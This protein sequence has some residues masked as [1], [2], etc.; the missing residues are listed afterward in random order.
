MTDLLGNLPSKLIAVHLNYRSRARQRAKEPAFPSYFLKAPSTL[1]SSESTIHRPADCELLAYE[2]EIAL[3]IGTE[4]H[5]IAPEVAWKHVSG[6]TAA[7]DFGLYDLRYADPGSNVHSKGLDGSTPIGPVVLNAQRLDPSSVRLRTWVN[8]TVVQDAQ[9]DDDMLFDFGYV[10]ADL[11][12]FMTL[13]PGDVILTGTPAGSSVVQPGDIVEVEVS[14][15]DLD[16]DPTATGR[17]RTFVAHDDFR[18]GHLHPVPRADKAAVIAAYGHEPADQ[19]A[20]RG[21]AKDPEVARARVI[22]LLTKVST[23]TI[24][25]QLRRR[26]IM[27]CTMSGLR[28]VVDRKLVGTART[29]RYVPLREDLFDARNAGMNAQKQAIEDLSPGEVLVIEARGDESAGTIGDI[30]A[31]RAQM[32]GAVGIVTDG[33]IRDAAGMEELAIPTFCRAAHP[34]PL[35]YRHVPWETGTAVSCAGVV[36]VPGDFVVGDSDGVVVVPPLLAEE[37]ALDCIEQELQ[38]K[39]IALQVSVGIPLPGLYPLAGEWVEAYGK[40]KEG[41][42]DE[43]RPR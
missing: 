28:R 19:G 10:I 14:G 9:V 15:T 8:G 31:L 29:I 2:G 22:D 3:V 34:A 39:F 32:K 27:G 36:V 11:S 20:H 24:S 17:L 38:E 42:E 21:L 1:A 5:R 13:H 4:G 25:S 35:G 41:I 30:L 26:G 18:V 37:V 12:R 23:A 16:G 7:N 43:E 33:A 40:W 6:I